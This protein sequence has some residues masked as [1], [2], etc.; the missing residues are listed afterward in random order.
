MIGHRRMSAEG[1][2]A[3]W[4]FQYLRS[5]VR[6]ETIMAD[7]ALDGLR[8]FDW[9]FRCFAKDK[10]CNSPSSC[11]LSSQIPLITHF[12]FGFRCFCRSLFSSCDIDAVMDANHFTPVNRVISNQKN[13][14]ISLGDFEITQKYRNQYRISI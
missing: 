7:A 8:S 3:P 10:R 4:V 5:Y 2:L 12:I 14:L 13:V 11:P 1:D 9:P 6:I